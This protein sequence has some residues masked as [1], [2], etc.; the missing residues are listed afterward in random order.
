[1]RRCGDGSLV[2]I[3]DETVDRTTGG[4]GR[5]RDLSYAELQQLDAGSGERIP[6]LT[7]VLD[8][9]AR[10][11]LLNVELKDDGIALDVKKL[12]LERKLEGQ[13]IVS[14]FDW[15]ELRPLVPDLPTALLSSHPEN[16]V[17][18]A[19]KRSAAAIHPRCDI[20]TASLVHAAHEAKL[21]VHVWTVNDPAEISRFREM[22][23]DGVFTDFPDG[24][25]VD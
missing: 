14:A 13:V 11:C 24:L 16:L 4:R 8:E 17:L 6:L 9:F 21:R 12:V 1:V 22:E 15:D 19:I 2:V 5:V 3:H 25:K 20:T 10:R 18:T 23:V 7:D